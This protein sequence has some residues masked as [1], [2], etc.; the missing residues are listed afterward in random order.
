MK[1]SKKRNTIE[2]LKILKEI[3]EILESGK[4]GR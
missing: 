4:N 2:A 1:D 3:Y